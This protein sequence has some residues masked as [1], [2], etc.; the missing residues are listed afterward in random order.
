MPGCI[1]RLSGD[2]MQIDRILPSVRPEVGIGSG[3]ANFVVSERDGTDSLGQIQDALSCLRDNRTELL[4]LP[5]SGVRSACL[6]FGLWRKDT[7]SQSVHLPVELVRASADLGISLE[8][9]I[10]EAEL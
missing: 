2:A 8:V 5:S 1:L 4:A 10:Y 6:D 9:S 7:M 3:A